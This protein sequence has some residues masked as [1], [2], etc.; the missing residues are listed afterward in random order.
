M[1]ESQFLALTWIWTAI[2]V[3]VLPLTLWLTPPFGRH[4]HDRFGPCI[5]NRIGWL[6]M[7]S[8]A[9]WYLA[10]V[11]LRG[12]SGSQSAAWMLWALWMVHYI[13]RGLVFPFRT[14]TTG[15]QI[16]VLVVAS[17]F[18]FQLVNGTLNGMALSS[19]GG[20]YTA[21]W[22][23]RPLFWIGLSVFAAGWATNIWS[24]EILLRLRKPGETGYHIPQGGLFRWVSCP[25][26]LGEVVQWCG[27]A[28][29]CWNPAALSFAVWTIANLLPRAL[30]HHRW[31]LEQFPN[32]PKHR[33]A[34]FP[35][36]L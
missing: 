5:G 32:Y 21:D 2:G 23:S 14:K 15:K 18:G 1:N 27:W 8:P 29:M 7:E 9:L 35:G 6:I 30:A 34:L 4:S 33:K 22:L 17:G 26:F 31:Y 13:N 3:S 36:L 19:F 10:L 24:D 25:N 11:F 12:V 20:A 28:L 16:P